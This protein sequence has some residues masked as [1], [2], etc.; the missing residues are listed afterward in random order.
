MKK[1]IALFMVLLAAVMMTGCSS[2]D[3]AGEA[4]K[5]RWQGKAKEKGTVRKE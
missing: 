3:D 5:S 2:S 4:E 1:N